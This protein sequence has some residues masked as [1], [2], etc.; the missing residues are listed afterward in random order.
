MGSEVAYCDCGTCGPLGAGAG[1][2]LP[3]PG[4]FLSRSRTPPPPLIGGAT[5]GAPG[6]SWAGAPPVWMIEVGLR[7]KPAIQDSNRLVTKKPAAKNAVVRVKTLAVPRP[8]IKPEVELTSPPPSD[9]CNST[10]EIRPRTSMRWMTIMTLSIDDFR[11]PPELD[12]GSRGGLYMIRGGISMAEMG[13]PSG[14]GRARR[15]NG[16]RLHK[17]SVSTARSSESSV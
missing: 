12:I 4:P 7:S 6:V 11:L 14:F 3:P 15:A 13:W 16:W 10:T 17:I 9:F 1:A 8:V 5:G 2:V